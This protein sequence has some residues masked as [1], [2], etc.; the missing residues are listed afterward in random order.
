ME[1]DLVLNSWTLP[2]HLWDRIEPLLPEYPL[3]SEGGR[4]RVDRRQ[5][6]NGIFYVM[7]TGCQWKAAPAEHGTGSTLHRYFQAWA[8]GGVFLKLWK[9][10]LME[11]DELKGICWD[12]QSIDGAMT[13]APLGGEKNRAE[14]DGSGE[15]RQQTLPAYRWRRRSFGSDG[16][17]RQYA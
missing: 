10:G 17:R 2:D 1:R 8:K 12:W 9:A 3:F 4:P 13:K 6:M 5:V 14:P 16:G 7:R 11:Y 15:I